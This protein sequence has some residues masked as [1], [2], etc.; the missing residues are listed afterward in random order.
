V[1]NHTPIGENRLLHCTSAADV[2]RLEADFR[3]IDLELGTV[4]H[5]AGM[6]IAHVYFPLGGMVSILTVMTT[7]EQIETAIVG[8]EGVVGALVGID[9]AHAT[10]QATVQI[11]G[12][13]WQ[14]PAGKFLAVYQTSAGF[15]ALMNRYVGIIHFQAQ[16]SAACHALHSVE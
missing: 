9:G 14:I 1:Q 6:P 2:A 12:T 15:R 5:P 8:R 16:Q 4:L 10:G 13:A 7:G 11:K 3:K